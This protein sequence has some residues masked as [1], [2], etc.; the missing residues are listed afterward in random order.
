MIVD[1]DESSDPVPQFL[2]F[3]QGGVF[4]GGICMAV[5]N[6]KSSSSLILVTSVYPILAYENIGWNEPG[7][8]REKVN[9]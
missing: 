8:K 4:N 1:D 7:K 2:V 6:F 3:L 9:L 5:A